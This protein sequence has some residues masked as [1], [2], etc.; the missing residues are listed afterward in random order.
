MVP[1]NK[2]IAIDG[3]AASGKS[4][5]ATRVS[6]KTGFL[7]V[8]SGLMYRAL[9]WSVLRADIDTNNESKV[10]DHLNSIEME[11]IKSNDTLLL[12]ID[13]NDPGEELKSEEVNR[14]V[15]VVAAIKEVRSELVKRQREYLLVSD[16][17]M[18]GRDI[19][20]VVFPETP[21]KFYID[22]SPEVR[23]LR[24]RGEGGV[25][26]LIARD[27][28]DSSRKVSPLV[29]PEDAFVI[30]TSEMNLDEVVEKVLSELNQKGL[31]T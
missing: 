25:D 4:S 15:S 27:K 30:D 6:E 29:I 7:H 10:I 12:H 19:G 31:I 3:P 20:S 16:I 28:L 8:N 21:F 23:A 24:R 1:S 9:T 13:G 2:V 5:V 17:V 26:D 11:C 14:S 22:A 18:E